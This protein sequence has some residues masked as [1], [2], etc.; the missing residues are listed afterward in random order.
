MRRQKRLELLAGEGGL[1]SFVYQR[2]VRC[3]GEWLFDGIILPEGNEIDVFA[4]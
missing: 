2:E 1:E 4:V 3:H